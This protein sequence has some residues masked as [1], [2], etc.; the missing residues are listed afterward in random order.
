M[1]TY[2]KQ[3]K[4]KDGN[5]IIPATNIAD[6]LYPV[7]SIYM[8]ATLS[9]TD[10]VANA[11]GG[12]WEKWG[13]G[14]V[15]VGVDTTQTEF[16]TVGKTGGE[17]TH[18]LTATEMPTHNHPIQYAL[19]GTG[20]GVN[21]IYGETYSASA[22]GGVYTRDTVPSTSGEVRLGIGNRGGGSEHNNLQPYI[23][24]YMYKRTA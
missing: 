20:G 4:D 7:G 19:L 16:N 1:A 17:K 23:T 6:Y 9:T 22:N 12:T 13:E 15:P 8:S 18:I 5:I 3:L 2:R 24:C 14:R 21:N 10:Q 11:L